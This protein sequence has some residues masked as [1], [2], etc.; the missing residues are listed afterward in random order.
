MKGTRLARLGIRGVFDYFR[1]DSPAGEPEA[2]TIGNFNVE[3]RKRWGL[4]I[5]GEKGLWFLKKDR[6]KI[7]KF[8]LL[9]SLDKFQYK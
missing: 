5:K 9:F 4:V 8:M 1:R 3:V 2:R 7:K 6:G